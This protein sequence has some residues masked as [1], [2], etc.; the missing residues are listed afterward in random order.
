M[1]PTTPTEKLE[2]T[3][4]EWRLIA[5]SLDLAIKAG[6]VS[7]ALPLLPI[8]SKIAAIPGFRPD[9]WTSSTDPK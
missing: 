6:G 1:E 2:L 7:H 9:S 3:L 4:H 5:D 8:W